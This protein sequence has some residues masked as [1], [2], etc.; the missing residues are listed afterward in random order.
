MIKQLRRW[1]ANIVWNANWLVL[2]RV[3]LRTF[4]GFLEGAMFH[5]HLR[6]GGTVDI[7][8]GDY[9]LERG[10]RLGGPTRIRLR[11][12]G[13]PCFHLGPDAP[14][15]V[16]ITPGARAAVHGLRFLGAPQ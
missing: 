8:P 4:G 15:A 11:G 14:A 13:A 5:L 7:P 12:F 2:P 10:L 6:R 16:T 3:N 1:V 9:Q